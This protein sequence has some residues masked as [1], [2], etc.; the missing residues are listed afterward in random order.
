[1]TFAQWARL[2]VCRSCDGRGWI[3]RGSH[4]IT[5]C[6]ACRGAGREVK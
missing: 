2:V 5:V 3:V 1:M 6:P 4:P